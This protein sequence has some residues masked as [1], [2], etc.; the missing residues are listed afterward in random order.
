MNL[1]AFVGN[2][3]SVELLLRHGLDN[4]SCDHDGDTPLITAV[5]TG[6]RDSTKIAGMVCA[7]CS[8]LIRGLH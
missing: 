1:A 2:V 4:E 6:G 7:T 8:L 3:A 5:K